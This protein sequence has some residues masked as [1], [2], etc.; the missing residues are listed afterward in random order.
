MLLNSAW[1]EA[2]I[3]PEITASVSQRLVSQKPEEVL[4]S[5][6][7]M[8]LSLTARHGQQTPRTSDGG[9]RSSK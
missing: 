3:T 7:L 4:G 6:Q 2:K 1:R 5:V 8:P 9:N